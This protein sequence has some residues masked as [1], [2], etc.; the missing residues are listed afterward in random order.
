MT[1]FEK[2]VVFSVLDVS[3]VSAIYVQDS[4]PLG[5]RYVARKASR[6][7]TYRSDR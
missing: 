6:A 5:G 2:T 1:A 3:T 7:L 4:N